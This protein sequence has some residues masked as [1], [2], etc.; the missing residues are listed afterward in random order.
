[1]R[2]LRPLIAIVPVVLGAS[3][4]G[5][6]ACGQAASSTGDFKGAKKD[7]A[8]AISDLDTAVKKSDAS[9]ICSDLITPALRNRLAGLARGVKSGKEQRGND[10]ADQL[11]YSIRDADATDIKVRS[12]TIKGKTATAKVETSV[13]K[14]ANPVDTITLVNA[15]GWRLNDLP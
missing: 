9:K 5:A 14:G 12:I 3:L 7:V 4:I 6:G 8:Q 11:K 1:M 13:T 15:D 2:R 10:C